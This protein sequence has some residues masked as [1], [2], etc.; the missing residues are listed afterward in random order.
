[1]GERRGNL[2]KD[3]TIKVRMTYADIA[4]L[5]VLKEKTGKSKSELMRSGLAL[6]YRK[7]MDLE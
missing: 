1:M 5:E 4:T 7:T 2:K 6:L 3:Q